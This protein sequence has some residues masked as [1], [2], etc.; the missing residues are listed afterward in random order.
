[1]ALREAGERAERKRAEEALRASEERFRTLMQFSFEVYWETEHLSDAPPPGYEIGKTRWGLPYLEPD[2]EAWRI[3]RETLDAH[4]PF[5]DFE[6]ARPT[7]DGGRLYLS[8]SGLPV[9]DKAGRFIGYRGVARDITERKRIEEALRQREKELREVVE[10]IPAMTVMALPDGSN[11]FASRRWSEYSG[12]SAADTAGSG[13]QAAVHPEDLDRHGRKRRESFASGEPFESEARFR[14]V[15]GEYRW[16]LVRWAPMR[17]GAGNVLRWYGIAADIEDRKRAEAVLREREAKIRRL[18]D[19][20]II[21]I[22]I[23]DFDGRILE[24]NDAFLHI[25]GYDRE[26]LVAGRI[27]WTDLTPPEWHDLDAR[28]IEENKLTGRLP[29][30]EKEYFRK[31]GSRVPVLIGV[32]TLEEGGSQGVAFVLDLTERKRAERALR[33]SEELKR[34]IIESSEDCI[35]VLDLDGNLLFMSSGG[36]QLLEIDNIQPYLNT[37]W[38]NFWEPEDRPK[39]SDSIAAA[40]AGGIGKFQAFCPSAKG[41]PRWWDVVTT[42]I[43]NADGQP[44][45]L[46][47]VSRDITE[48][49][50]AEAEARESERRYREMQ[51]QLAHVNRVATMG[52]L[53]ASIAHEVNQPI[54]ATVAN[55][56]AGLRW[57]G[58]RPPN[59]DEIREIRQALDRIARDGAR[60]GA[61]VGRIRALIKGTPPRDERVEIN[62]AIREVIELTGSETVKNGVLVQTDLAE[63][64]PL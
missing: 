48:R 46:L 31:N 40:R 12:L 45:Q 47:S 32:A 33:D 43:C 6:F 62:A 7:P 8:T 23:W 36:Q 1:R 39:I 18:V 50:Q 38:I 14:A 29:P 51:M 52:Q 35:K 56:Q 63:G 16:F 34:R 30:F 3:H 59:L 41:A 22:F 17:D 64:L 26:E 37:C 9:F 57:L 5:R 20:N 19:S 15:D 49:K 2:E 60:A 13:W 53:T 27:R 58:S 24:S 4:L 21:G 11:V 10:T 28:M 44:E 55:A 61:V 25:V 42:P 54:A